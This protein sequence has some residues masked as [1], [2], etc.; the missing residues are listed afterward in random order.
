MPG[1]KFKFPRDW[2]RPSTNYILFENKIAIIMYSE[3]TRR[4][5]FRIS[6]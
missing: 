2:V 5:V 4:L 1:K 6:L 3:T